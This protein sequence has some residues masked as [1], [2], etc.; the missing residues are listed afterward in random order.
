MVAPTPFP[1]LNEILDELVDTTRAVLADNFVGAYLQGSFAVGDADERWR[2]LM[3]HALDH[4]ADP[5]V[6]V[7]QSADPWTLPMTWEFIKVAVR[8]VAAAP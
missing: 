6:R 5:W 8:S 2:S 3:Q 7:H 4:R 1:E